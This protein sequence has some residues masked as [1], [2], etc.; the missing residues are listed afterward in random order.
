M[1]IIEK[2][3]D[4][5]DGD[6]EAIAHGCNCVGMMG[7]GIAAEFRRRWPDMYDHYSRL[8]AAELFQ[9]GGVLAWP[10]DEVVIYNL[11]TQAL[12]GPDATLDAI[13]T[14]VAQMCF[15]AQEAGISTIGIP[16]IGAG[17]GGLIWDDVLSTITSVCPDDVTIVVYTLP[18]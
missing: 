5:F 6:E 4:L 12:P 1:P 3:G 15:D 14:S 9:P 10:T 2:T 17:I 11:A 13:A 18:D 7:A 16:R 8:C